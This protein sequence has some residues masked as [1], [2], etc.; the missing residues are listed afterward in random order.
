MRST[1]TP[2]TE[3]TIFYYIRKNYLHSQKCRRCETYIAP[4]STLDNGDEFLDGTRRIFYVEVWCHEW[5]YHV[6][7]I[8]YYSSHTSW[9][10]FFLHVLICICI[11]LFIHDFIRQLL[12]HSGA[13]RRRKLYPIDSCLYRNLFKRPVVHSCIAPSAIF[14]FPIQPCMPSVRQSLRIGAVQ[15]TVFT[16]LLFYRANLPICSCNLPSNT[17]LP[18]VLG[19]KSGSVR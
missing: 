16:A 2:Q 6:W 13:R 15:T 12:I 4:Y 18:V 7:I 5:I 10:H 3:F 19:W 17:I 14:R 8:R 9:E 1:T 11:L